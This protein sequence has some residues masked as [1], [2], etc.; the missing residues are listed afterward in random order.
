MIESSLD[1]LYIAAALFFL[2]LSVITLVIGFQLRKLLNEVQSILDTVDTVIN[3]PIRLLNEYVG[4][5][6]QVKKFF[7]KFF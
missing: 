4:K 2:S 6:S 5:F 3:T 1:I 7:E